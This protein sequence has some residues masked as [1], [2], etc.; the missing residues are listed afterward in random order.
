[1]ARADEVKTI[2]KFKYFTLLSTMVYIGCSLVLLNI[3]L[4]YIWIY[5]R[6]AGLFLGNS[7]NFL[8]RM[9]ISWNI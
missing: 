3:G 5:H 8:I 2:P 6:A 4:G 1:M 7:I 9:V